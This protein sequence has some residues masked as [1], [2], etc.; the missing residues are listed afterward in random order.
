MHPI[1]SLWFADHTM[2]RD[3]DKDGDGIDKLR[4]VTAMLVANEITDFERDIE[5]W[6]RRFD[7][8]D[9]G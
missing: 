9:R 4:F 2:L 5:P 8:L 1:Y 6:I 3:L 7:E